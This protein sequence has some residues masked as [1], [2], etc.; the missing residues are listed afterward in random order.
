MFVFKMQYDRP[1]K[2]KIRTYIGKTE[3]PEFL[4]NWRYTP[5]N[6]KFENKNIKEVMTDFALPGL[7][8]VFYLYLAI[9][10]DNYHMQLAYSLNPKSRLNAKGLQ[11]H[12]HNNWHQRNNYNLYHQFPRDQ[13]LM[14]MQLNFDDGKSDIVCVSKDF[15]NKF[16]DCMK[17]EF[18]I[19]MNEYQA[20]DEIHVV[21]K[22]REDILRELEL[23]DDELSTFTHE[24]WPVFKQKF[25]KALCS[26]AKHFSTSDDRDQFVENVQWVFQTHAPK[27]FEEFELHRFEEWVARNIQ[28]VKF[29]REKFQNE[30]LNKLHIIMQQYRAW[31]EMYAKISPGYAKKLELNHNNPD[32]KLSKTVVSDLKPG[33]YANRYVLLFDK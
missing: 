29:Q 12:M 33:R 14:T 5:G 1:C 32:Y 6:E 4:Q 2:F 8:G 24:H 3:L 10:Y 27:L 7:G 23:S 15:E 21:A 11:T 17:N 30:A 20:F 26:L 9:S 31:M 19:E 28:Q 25:E 13:R 22:S 18:S 16:I